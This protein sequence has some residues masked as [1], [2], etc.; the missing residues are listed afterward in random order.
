[1]AGPL[2]EVPVSRRGAAAMFYVLSWGFVNLAISFVAGLVIA[3]I[4]SPSEFGLFAIGQTIVLL[5][6]VMADGGIASG[7]IRQKHG[8]SRSVLKTINGVQ[9]LIGLMIATVVTPI[10][11]QFGLGG[12]L[13]ALIVWSLPIA[14]LQTA[15]R[16]VL[17]RDLH[18]R[19]LSVIDAVGVLFYY[20]WA[21]AGLLVGFGVWSL[22]SAILVR[23][24]VSTLV[25]GAIVNWSLLVPSLTRY[26]DVLG[27]IGFGIRFSLTNLTAVLYEQAKNIVIAL[28]DGTYALGL[29]ALTARILQLP[30]LVYQPI[31]QLGFPAFSQF[32]AAGKNPKPM[33]ER[34][35]RLSFASSA[36]LLPPLL[37][38]I[39]SLISV[40]FGA[41]WADAAQIFPGVLLS[42]FVGQSIGA[43]CMHYLYAI[44]RPSVVLKITVVA[45]VL[46]LVCIALLLQVMGLWGI[47]FGTVPGAVLESALLG[48]IVRSSTGANLFTAL[49]A[50]LAAGG[51]ATAGGFFVVTRVGHE[52]VGGLL[53]AGA[54]VAIAALTSFVARRSDFADL[55]NVGR[56]SVAAVRAGEG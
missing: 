19:D 45:V 47:G 35:A 46:N 26:R 41:Q 18:F 51:I 55:L 34:V 24:T 43:P 48:A 54:A 11:L 6:G 37:V 16:V 3:R 2:G 44:D 53:G 15:G 13:A 32:V 17:A 33:L 30:F 21:I 38:A 42:I 7:F 28:V 25:T 40:C 39:P 8:I 49:P 9:F 56:R 5:A 22:A 23:A 27:V 36:L 52:V 1:L 4:L 29:W 50:F 14:S 20:C 12:A 31:H 10:A